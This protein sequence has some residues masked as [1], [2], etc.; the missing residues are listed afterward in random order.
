MRRKTIK[1]TIT[2]TKRSAHSVEITIPNEDRLV[3][4]LNSDKKFIVVHLNGKP[5]IINKSDILEIEGL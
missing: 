4:F 5:K 1:V 3:D 2:T